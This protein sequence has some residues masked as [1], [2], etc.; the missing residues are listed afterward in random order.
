MLLFERFIIHHP[1]STCIDNCFSSFQSGRPP[2]TVKDLASSMTL[3]ALLTLYQVVGL[4]YPLLPSILPQQTFW[5]FCKGGR[6]H[7]PHKVHYSTMYLSDN[8]PT[9][10]SP[11]HCRINSSWLPLVVSLLWGIFTTPVTV[12]GYGPVLLHL[13]DF[14]SYSIVLVMVKT[15]CGVEEVWWAT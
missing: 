15:W 1:N 7:S 14:N 5:G 4:P 2:S 8:R 13:A 10:V 11:P 3:M 9:W 6:W 12:P